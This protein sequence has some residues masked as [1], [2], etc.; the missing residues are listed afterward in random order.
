MMIGWMRR[1]LLVDWLP[2]RF[3]VEKLCKLGS[4]SMRRFG[5]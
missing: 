4:R 5:L 2:V 1:M 3:E